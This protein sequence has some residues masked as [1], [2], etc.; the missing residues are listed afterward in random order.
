M[1]SRLACKLQTTDAVGALLGE[2]DVWLAALSQRDLDGSAV[3]GGYLV[4]ARERAAVGQV[5]DA[6]GVVAGVPESVGVGDDPDRL[7]WHWV[8]GDLAAGGDPADLA[9]RGLGE[10]QGAVG[11]EHDALRV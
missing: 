6:G 5:S 2:P 8:L 4:F 3:G 7:R 10:P 9:G 11:A 1:R